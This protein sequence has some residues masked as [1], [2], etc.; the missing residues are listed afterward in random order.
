MPHRY[1]LLERFAFSLVFLSA[2]MCTGYIAWESSP[3]FRQNVHDGKELLLKSGE[4]SYAYDA[5][6]TP[7][8]KACAQFV[9][10]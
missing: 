4:Y 5:C 7:S 10:Q 9:L 3:D 2:V 1:Q 8:G 6:A